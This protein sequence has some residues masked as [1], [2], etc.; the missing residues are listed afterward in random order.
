MEESCYVFFTSI[1]VFC[2]VFI[3]FIFFS[4]YLFLA[5]SVSLSLS[6]FWGRRISSGDAK[7]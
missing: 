4:F 2:S 7:R 3:C 1:T 6:L 5:L